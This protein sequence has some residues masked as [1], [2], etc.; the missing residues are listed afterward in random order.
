MAE[1]EKRAGGKRKLKATAARNGG[2]L[3]S[4]LQASTTCF[5]SNLSLS[6]IRQP[7]QCCRIAQGANIGKYGSSEASWGKVIPFSAYIFDYLPMY[8]IVH[9]LL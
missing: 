7:V 2:G 6:L 3:P 9:Y 1:S 4:T 5:K 8:T